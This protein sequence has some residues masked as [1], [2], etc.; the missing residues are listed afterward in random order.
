MD[1]ETY[2]LLDTFNAYLR[3]LSLAGNHAP[4]DVIAA[5][6]KASELLE[7]FDLDTNPEGK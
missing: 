5:C 7:R 6:D 4:P 1:Q 2:D 3:A